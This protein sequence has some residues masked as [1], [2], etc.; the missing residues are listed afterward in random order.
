MSRRSEPTSSTGGALK[1]LLGSSGLGFLYCREDLLADIVPTVTG[2]FADEDI[3]KMDIYDY[4]PSSTARKFESGTPPIPN[5]YAGV[6]GMDLMHEIGIAE[7][8]R[9]RCET[10][11]TARRGPRSH[12]SEDRDAP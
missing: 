9:A 4:S 11:R 5:I 2:W 7:T 8:E 3:F 10:H 1:Y 12:W 6:A